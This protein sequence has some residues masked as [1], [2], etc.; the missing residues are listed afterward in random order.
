M[1]LRLWRPKEIKSV[2]HHQCR[3]CCFLAQFVFEMLTDGSSYCLQLSE[4]LIQALCQMNVITIL[5]Q[6]VWE[7]FIVMHQF[8][9]FSSVGQDFSFFFESLPYS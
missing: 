5:V 2:V 3:T 7:A 8:V 6:D 9:I 1:H 4:Q